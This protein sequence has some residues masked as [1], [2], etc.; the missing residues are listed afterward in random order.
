[1][2]IDTY[3]SNDLSQSTRTMQL[4]CEMDTKYSTSPMLAGDCI[5]LVCFIEKSEG[6]YV[7]RRVVME[8]E[9]DQISCSFEAAIPSGTKVT[10]KY[11]LDEVSWLEFDAEPT[12]TVIS[13]EFNRYEYKKTE[14]PAGTKEYRVMLEMETENPLVRPRVR[15]LINILRQVGE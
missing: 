12:V 7:S 6:A 13:D 14:I 3:V 2:P 10:P 8:Q 15:R 4:R 5:N 11:T 9:Y 1:M